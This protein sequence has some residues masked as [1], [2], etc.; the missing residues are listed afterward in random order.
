MMKILIS[1]LKN[2]KSYT[3]EWNEQPLHL[4]F[5]LED[6]RRKERDLFVWKSQC[7]AQNFKTNCGPSSGYSES[8]VTSNSL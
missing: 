5:T 6:W 8:C 1:V 7:K 4:E 3:N 2:K